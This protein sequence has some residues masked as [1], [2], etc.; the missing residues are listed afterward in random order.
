MLSWDDY[1]QEDSNAAILGPQ[2]GGPLP[3]VS[4]PATPEPAAAQHEASVPLMEKNQPGLA[5]VTPETG[6]AGAVQERVAPEVTPAPAAD[7]NTDAVARAAA[8]V[9]AI[10]VAPGLEELEMGAARVSVDEKAMINCRADLN[11]LVP[12]KYDWAWQ[13]Y[14]DGCATGCRRKST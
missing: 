13:K 4:Q 14:I 12:F 2:S 11:Q 9:Q 5:A 8:A 6:S 1:H 3:A 10:D 7:K